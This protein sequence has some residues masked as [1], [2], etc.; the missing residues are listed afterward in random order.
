[1]VA[2]LCAACVSSGTVQC[3]DKTVCSDGTRCVLVPNGAYQCASADQLSACGQVAEGAEC[4]LNGKPGTCFGGGCIVAV[5]GDGV[6]DANPDVEACDD[7]NTLS[8]DGCSA[9]CMSME[10]CGNG[11]IDVAV[12]EECDDGNTQLSGDGCTGHCKREYR[13]WRDVTPQQPQVRTG[14]GLVTDPLHG[15][16]MIGGGAQSNT[17]FQTLFNDTWRWDGGTWIEA[18][19]IEKPGLRYDATYTYDARRRRVIM[20]GGYGNSGTV[21][22]TTFEWDGL[23][24]KERTSATK[25]TSRSGAGMACNLTDCVLFGGLSGTVLN[26]TWLWN[27]SAWTEKTFTT[28]FPS[29][30]TAAAMAYDPQQNAVVLYGGF[31]TNGIGLTDIWTY[32]ADTWTRR[33]IASGGTGVTGK[34]SMARDPSRG[35]IVLVDAVQTSVL[36]TPASPTPWSLSRLTDPP[37]NIVSPQIAWDP[38]TMRLYA[39]GLSTSG[40]DLVTATLSGNVWTTVSTVRRPTSGATRTPAAYDPRRG[41]TIVLDA[42][43]GTFEWMGHGWTF[44]G[45]AGV[46]A[47]DGVALANDPVCGVTLSFGGGPANLSGTKSNDVFRFPDTM[48]TPTWQQLA[49]TGPLPP[50][51]THH[52]M[53]YDADRHVFVVF[54]GYVNGGDNVAGDTWELAS[55][56]CSAWVWT[57]RTQVGGPPVRYDAQLVY[58]PVRKLTVLFGGQGT[59]GT[60]SLAD[61]WEWNGT[62]WI[63]RTPTT[64]PPARYAHGMALDPRR[65]KIV[66]FGGKSDDGGNDTW[67]WNGTGAGLWTRLAPAV[68]PS[69]RS[70]MGFAQDITGGLIAIDGN[71]GGAVIVGVQRLTSELSTDGVDACQDATVDSDSDMAKGCTDPDCWTRCTPMCPPGTSCPSGPRCGDSMCNPFEDFLLCPS[72]CT[73]PPP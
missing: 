53:A 34:S 55:T 40:T 43:N 54:G 14:F 47:K 64:S 67:E 50:V 17:T 69:Q 46:N 8:S 35:K 26:D 31:D 16:T 61:T 49:P 73:T 25:P 45:V 44:R 7:G 37:T 41:T 36:D 71:G 5:C 19:P 11:V 56:N 15:A 4:S 2:V 6:L 27:G 10:T 32:S 29:A 68:V 70:G 39:V 65:Q 21:S 72:D 52:S 18:L 12:G 58:D 1:M 51:R 60:P 28:A 9:D 20:F 22:A 57:E 66:L 23:A 42:S 3:P 38:D 59:S 13:L 62:K 63:Q 33:A 48:G 30:R 24:W